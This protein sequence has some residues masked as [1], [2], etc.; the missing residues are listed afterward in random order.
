MRGGRSTTR[1]SSLTGETKESL[2]S[3]LLG[4]VEF[5]KYLLMSG[6]SY[7]LMG[8]FQTDRLEAEFGVYRYV[9]LYYLLYYF[10]L[11]LDFYPTK[12]LIILHECFDLQATIGR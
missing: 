3:T 1:I 11:T 12:D 5:T 7:V 6:H 2:S 8:H 10:Y 9:S 4:L